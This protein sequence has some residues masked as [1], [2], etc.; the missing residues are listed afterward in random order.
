MFEIRMIGED[1]EQD[2]R[3]LVKA[4]F[5]E[6]EFVLT[7]SL[8]GEADYRLELHLY[9]KWFF[10]K[11]LANGKEYIAREDFSV[12]EQDKYQ[13]CGT[14]DRRMYRNYLHRELYHILSEATGKELPWGTLTGVR[15]TKQVL[16]RLQQKLTSKETLK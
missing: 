9:S 4:F 2:I 1:Y 5:P 6:E 16:D 14:P 15:P 12:R 11:F 3:P 13:V 8:E 10:L 7:S